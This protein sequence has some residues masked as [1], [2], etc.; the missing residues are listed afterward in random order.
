MSNCKNIKGRHSVYKFYLLGG[1]SILYLIMAFKYQYV[2]SD[3]VRASLKDSY[4]RIIP[5]LFPLMVLSKFMSESG[6][7]VVFEYLLGGIISKL[8]G[9]SRKSST[10]VVLGL[11]SG[12]PVGAMSVSDLFEEGH[13]SK[14]EAEKALIASHNAGPAFTIGAIGISLWGSTLFGVLLY[15]SQ[16]FSGLIVVWIIDSKDY[17][18]NCKIDLLRYK[19]SI[20]I[21]LVSAVSSA[22][23]SCISVIGF[24]TFWRGI[25]DYLFHII[26]DSSIIISYIFS[27]LLEFA[28]GSLYAYFAS[29]PYSAYLA[30]FALGFG[31]LSAICQAMGYTSKA[32]LSTTKMLLAKFLQGILCGFFVFIAYFVVF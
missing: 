18:R 4:S 14:N 7:I 22:S 28:S 30:G 32:G 27:A 25:A 1:V 2:F 21:S 10:A 31:G 17:S 5:S 12:F 15:L 9:I 26:P 20:G 13:I 19:K 11:L 16:L 3:S 24:I 23:I 8:Y 6:I 29:A